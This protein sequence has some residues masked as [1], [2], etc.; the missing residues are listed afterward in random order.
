[1]RRTAKEW[2]GGEPGGI[3]RGLQL[4]GGRGGLKKEPGGSKFGLGM[5]GGAE[6][7]GGRR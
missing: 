1:M 2:P 7:D 4:A 3:G 5:K 6:G